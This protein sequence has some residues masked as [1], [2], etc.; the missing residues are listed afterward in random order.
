MRYPMKTRS[1]RA[2]RGE[3]GVQLSTETLQRAHRA[4][5]RP[6]RG[7]DVK[8][9]FRV[10]LGLGA[11]AALTIPALAIGASQ[12]AGAAATVDTRT[13]ALSV[14]P[15]NLTCLQKGTAT[16]TASV[17]V[18]RGSL[19]DTGTLTAHNLKPGLDFDVFTVQRSIFDSGF[20]GSFGLAWYQS[21]LHANSSG[22]AS[23]TIKTI[24]LD[25]IFGF[26]P[27]KSLAPTNT[28]HLGFWF[29]RPADATNCGFT[30]VTPFN[31]DHNAGPLA[32][33]SRP[34]NGHGPLK[35]GS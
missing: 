5:V 32:M 29:N 35:T 18:H 22:D 13:F 8:V 15:T 16:P 4:L 1:L 26:D 20:T 6:L 34:V 14:N 30:G 10:F 2:V 21:D 12:G 27:D 3:V 23:T 25:Q 28:F 11:A 33:I 17:T 24:L 9:R 31:G 19:N 7:N